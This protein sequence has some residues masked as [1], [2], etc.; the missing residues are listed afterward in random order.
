MAW[1]DP[2]KTAPEM[3]RR[4]LEQNADA[5]ASGVDPACPQPDILAA[6]FERALDPEETARY[7]MHFSK[8]ARCREQLVVMAR[9]AEILIADEEKA[10][11]ASRAG[12]FGNWRWL[13]PA[14][15][16]AAVLV[17]ALV[18]DTRRS[19]SPNLVAVSRAPESRAKELAQQTYNT[20][21]GGPSAN[22]PAQPVPPNLAFDKKQDARSRQ[23]INTS[24]LDEN[25]QNNS[26]KDDESNSLE[27]SRIEIRR[28]A[29]EHAVAKNEEP[30]ASAG[31]PQSALSSPAVTPAPAPNAPIMP[32]AR[33]AETSAAS[34]TMA[35]SET[36]AAQANLK[37]K[38]MTAPVK[39]NRFAAAPD[40]LSAGIRISTPD[41]R[42]LWRIRSAGLV[43]KSADG[44][45]T[46]QAQLSNPDAHF[47]AGSAPAAQICWV[48]GNSGMIFVTKDGA[49]W[50]TIPP[51]MAADFVAVAAKDA[52]SATVTTADGRNFSTVDAGKHWNPAQ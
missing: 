14:A 52:L 42:V 29:D 38:Q 1:Q 26:A 33:S 49:A 22:A 5:G 35:R 2:N 13:A 41:S 47:V 28:D 40:K 45:A 12:W 48:V 7:E 20:A 18:W 50:M 44:G 23:S 30:K 51:P 16:V 11:R 17:F 24:E 8:C 6:Y 3:L 21:P 36:D 27:K 9:A 15:T 39:A 46:W 25:L 37:A 4:S 32:A 19:E 10:R 31:A 43:E 34:E